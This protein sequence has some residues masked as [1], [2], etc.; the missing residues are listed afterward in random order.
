MDIT[1]ALQRA[2]KTF[3]M[4]TGALAARMGLAVS[5]L[6][7]KVSPTYAT[8]HVSPEEMAEI[9]EVTGDHGALHALAGRLGYVLMPAPGA[10]FGD[11][12]MEALA[13]T[14]AEF[15]QFVAEASRGLADGK[16]SDNERMRIEREGA[17]A[18]AAIERLIA[19]A[20]KMNQAG[21][22][23]DVV[24]LMSDRAQARA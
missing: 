21:K 18:L 24:N 19:L 23:A 4:G 5:S 1:I 14:V 3:P 2:V 10:E 9:M 8:A 17:D 11:T 7:H 12:S 22:P 20:A 16:V 13:A 6:L 15:G